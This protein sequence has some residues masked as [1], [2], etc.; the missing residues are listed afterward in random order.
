M[1]STYRRDTR[2]Q[3]EFERAIK[4]ASQ[5]EQWLMKDVWLPEM[6]ARGF[7]IGAEDNG[8]DNSGSFQTKVNSKPDFKIN[9]EGLEGLIEVKTNPH[10]AKCTWKVESLN[11]CI[12]HNATILLFFNIATKSDNFKKDT[13]LPQ[14]KWTLIVPSIIKRWLEIYDS[15]IY[16]GFNGNKLSI[17]FPQQDYPGW[18][19][20][21]GLINFGGEDD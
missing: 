13:S 12:Q 18:F 2:T 7:D 17:Q 14:V 21:Y 15:K 19:K 10:F 9:L 4:R 20:I 5:I 11:A 3:A 16:Y 1:S 6:K 8:T